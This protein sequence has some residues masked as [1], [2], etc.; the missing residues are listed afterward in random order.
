MQIRC[1]H[2][3]GSEFEEFQTSKSRVK[4]DYYGG[5]LYF[6]DN[7]G[8]AKQYAYAM[9]KVAKTKHNPLAIEHI[10]T[11]ELK[12]NKIFDVDREYTG[13]ELTKLV[14][15]P[16]EFARSAGLLKYGTDKYEVI[17][18]ISSGDIVMTGD[19]L[20]RGLS[21]GMVKTAKAREQ[22]KKSGYDGLRYN[23]GQVTPSWGSVHIKHNVYIPYYPQNIKILNIEVIK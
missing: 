18:R 23:G 7:K 3:S 19:E 1:Y 5:Q 6:T 11:V 13:K 21:G 8:V 12:M 17:A 9:T 22:L 14:K 4:D 2:G 15:N 10:Y 16:E 20:F